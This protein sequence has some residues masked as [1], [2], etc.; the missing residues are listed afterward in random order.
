[1]H[2]KR[3]VH[4]FLLGTGMSV[5]GVGCA[6]VDALVSS[7]AGRCASSSSPER[8]IAVG[9]VFEN[10][11]RMSQA[12]AM[13]RQALKSDPGNSIARE[14]MEFIASI[15]SGRT[16]SPSELRSKEAIAVADSLQSKQQLKSPSK[17]A[18]NR[19]TTELE[20]TLAATTRTRRES[21][22]SEDS[23]AFADEFKDDAGWVQIV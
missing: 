8:L 21:P 9:R 16:F 23:K 13:Y 6:A 15:S 18:T 17:Q 1:M 3:L 19:R 10:Q 11:G 12:Q 20:S 7:P 22:P 4:A 2:W 14:R 5:V